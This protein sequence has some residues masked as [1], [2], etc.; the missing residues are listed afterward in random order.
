MRATIRWSARTPWEGP[1]ERD[2]IDPPGT[3]IQAIANASAE[4]APLAIQCARQP[5]P[6]A[7]SSA[8]SIADT[9]LFGS[10]SKEGHAE[11]RA[12]FEAAIG[13]DPNYGRAH[14]GIAPTV[15]SMIGIQRSS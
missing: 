7:A 3:S 2:V 11:A 6:A 9:A 5:C 15:P 1:A 14:T 10:Q 13:I 8:T 4:T 12:A